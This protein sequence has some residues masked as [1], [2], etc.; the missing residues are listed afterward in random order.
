MAA[1]IAR[2]QADGPGEIE[3]LRAAVTA[4]DTLPYT[5]PPYWHYPIRQSLGTAHLR[6]GEAALAE[7]VFEE[8]LADF[9]DNAWSL[10]G[11]QQARVAQGA[12]GAA[13]AEAVAAAW[14]YSDI[15]PTSGP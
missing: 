1:E 14:H 12:D 13:L 4:Q 9:P 10:F 5:E 3:H 8:D 7:A 15:E 6:N 2:A 11:L